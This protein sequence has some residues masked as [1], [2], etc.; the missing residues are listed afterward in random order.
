MFIFKS[1]DMVLNFNF[2]VLD[3]FF[4]CIGGIIVIV[5][6]CIGDDF[7]CVIILFK[8]ENGEWVIGM[9]FD[10]VYLSYKVL[11]V[12][13]FFCGLVWLFGVFYMSKY[14][15]VCDVLG[16][17]I[18]V[19]YVGVDV[20]LELVLFKDKICFYGIGKMGGYFVVD[21]KFGVD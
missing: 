11:M 17:V 4:V 13:E 19:L 9:L 1:G 20:C 21:G 16:K 7:V 2:I 12:G 15:F 10:C 6:V 5:F 8:K 14:E 3:K 18:G